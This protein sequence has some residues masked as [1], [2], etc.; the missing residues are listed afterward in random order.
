M[1]SVRR[2][3]AIGVLT[4]QHVYPRRYE[5]DE[6]ARVMSPRHFVEVRTTRGGP[7]PSETA[8]ALHASRRALDADRTWLAGER[9]RLERA[10]AERRARSA[11]L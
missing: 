10:A 4:M 6:M 11:A 1:Q 5:D 9:D 2:Q 8:K 3:R 7:A